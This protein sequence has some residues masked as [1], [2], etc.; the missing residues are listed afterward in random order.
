MVSGDREFDDVKA[1]VK[2]GLKE[3]FSFESR[4]FGQAVTISEVISVI[5]GVEGVEA[6]DIEYLYEHTED[7]GPKVKKKEDMIRAVG[8]EDADS[9]TIPSLLLI[10]ED[11]I[12]LE[13]MMQQP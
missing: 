6:V 7:S 11:K 4:D 12:T 5:Q 3:A 9:V 1:A 8:K 2:D 10:N 13:K